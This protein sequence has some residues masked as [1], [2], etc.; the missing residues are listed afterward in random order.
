MG[1]KPTPKAKLDKIAL[2]LRLVDS[3]YQ[4]YA[5]TETTIAQR[6]PLVR[7]SPV[8]LPRIAPQPRISAD[9]R[10]MAILRQWDTIAMASEPGSRCWPTRKVP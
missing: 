1:A 2:R 10:R 9:G 7:K 6:S 4:Q 8:V 5:K 3:H